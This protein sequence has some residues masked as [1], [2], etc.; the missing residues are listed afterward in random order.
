MSITVNIEIQREFTMNGD[1]DTVFDLLADVPRSVAHF[2]KVEKLTDLGDNTYRWE[3]EKVGVDKHNIQAV[4]ACRYSPDKSRGVIDWEPVKGEGNGL[5]SGR[6]DI[7]DNGDGTTGLQ[8][9]TEAE[10]TL[11]LPGI[12][13]MAVSPVIKHEFNGLVDTYINNLK[14]AFD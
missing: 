9:R 3:M 5:V 11:P 13:K 2:P 6:W 1:Y 12:L 7:R 10:M 8:F 14:K 4:Y